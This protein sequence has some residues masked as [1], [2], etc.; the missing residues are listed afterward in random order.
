M[1]AMSPAG[2]ANIASSEI[3]MSNSALDSYAKAP[4]EMIPNDSIKDLWWW[5]LRDLMVMLLNDK[6]WF[7]FEICREY[8]GGFSNLE[9][10]QAHRDRVPF[11]FLTRRK[12][13]LGAYHHLE[14][15]AVQRGTL[16]PDWD[17]VTL[18][19]SRDHRFTDERMIYDAVF[20]KVIFKNKL[21]ILDSFTLGDVARGE[22]SKLNQASMS[23]PIGITETM[24]TPLDDIKR[25]RKRAGV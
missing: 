24:D 18:Y 15:F 20:A 8:Q 7:E 12:T 22:L 9:I 21:Y 25:I 11:S 10:A 16:V 5:Y 3:K 2:D 23:M 1:N 19:G 4:K 17:P 14:L 13:Q 6:L